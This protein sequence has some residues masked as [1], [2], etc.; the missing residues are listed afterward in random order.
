VLW[1]PGREKIAHKKKEQK[2]ICFAV[3]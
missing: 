1:W 3:L 2:N